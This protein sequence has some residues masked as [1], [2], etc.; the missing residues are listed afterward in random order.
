MALILWW[1]HL[2]WV[3]VSEEVAAERLFCS[4]AF[5]GVQ[6]QHVIKQV[7]GCQRNTKHG[8]GTRWKKTNWFSR[9][10][11]IIK[12]NYRIVF[13]ALHTRLTVYTSFV[14]SSPC[15]KFIIRI[16]NHW[17]RKSTTYILSTSMFPPMLPDLFTKTIHAFIRTLILINFG[18]SSPTS[19]KGKM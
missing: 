4:T 13:C 19:I 17:R 3:D 14:K 12:E 7:Q 10:K 16:C 15:A 18:N 2:S 11:E 8:R 1:R 6:S 5:T 9:K